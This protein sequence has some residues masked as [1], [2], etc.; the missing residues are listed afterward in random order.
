MNDISTEI[1]KEVENDIT[2]YG[3]KKYV[4]AVFGRQFEDMPQYVDYLARAG[5]KIPDTVAERGTHRPNC[6]PLPYKYYIDPKYV[7]E[8]VE[9]IWMKCW[10]VA[11]RVEDIPNVGDRVAYDVGPLSFL[12]VRTSETSFKAFWNSCRH[13]ARRLCGDTPESGDMIQCPF[14]AWSY[15]LDGKLIWVPREEEFPGIQLEKVGLRPVQCDTWGGNVFINP[16]LNAPPLSEALGVMPRHFRDC[17]QENRYTAIRIKKKVK[18][19]WKSGLEAFLEGYHVLTTHPSGMPIFGSTYTQT[20]CWDDD[21]SAV[22]RL[23]TPAL[24]PDG[25]VQNE[26]SPRLSLELFCNTYGLP[27]PPPERGTTVADA[28]EYAAQKTAE[29]Y[30]QTLGIDFRDRSISYLVDMHQWFMFPAFFPW[31]GEGL[32]WWYNF[33]P[34]G[35][36]PDECV[37]EIR[38]LQPLPADGSAP[39]TAKTVWIDFNEKGRDYPETG[40]VGYIMD[41]DMENM[42]EVHR[43]MKATDPRV[44]RPLLA[45]EQEIRIRHFH[46]AY[47]RAM[48]IS[49]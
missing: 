47:M 16:D 15:G 39:P 10:Q 43:G 23:I 6:R 42:E 5:E 2:K 33:T 22:S 32:P 29:K 13:R 20:D 12:V 36:S 44:A 7:D 9:K 4:R 19:N 46:E 31:W 24:V 3:N 41:E 49:D 30:L 48:G 40:Q 21:K 11:C 27:F 8:E 28:R 18:I 25:W 34:L 26:V 38:L 37:M 1:S 14:H 35:N 45:T 17:P